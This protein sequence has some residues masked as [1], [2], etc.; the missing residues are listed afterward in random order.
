VFIAHTKM[1]VSVGHVI[2]LELQKYVI[3]AISTE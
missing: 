1:A 2:A 3:I